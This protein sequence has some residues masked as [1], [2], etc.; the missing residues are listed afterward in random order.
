M[1]KPSLA[2]LLRDDPAWIDPEP[3]PTTFRLDTLDKDE[4]IA[5]LLYRRGIRDAESAHD[6][7]DAK[8][9]PPPPDS[10]VPHMPAAIDRVSRAIE[11]GEQVG[12]FGDYDVDGVTATALL[13]HALRIAIGPG[14]VLP[15]L[16]ERADGYGLSRGG[17]DRIVASGARLM[18]CVDCGSTDHENVAY[19]IANGLDVVILDH[20][21]MTDRGPDE[22]IVV[23]PQLDTDPTYQ[24]LTGVGLAYL[25]VLGL[26]ARNHRIVEDGDETQ[27]LDLVAL[28]TVA[29]VQPLLGLNRVF[30]RE[31]LQAI[32]QTPRPGIQAL[33]S[34]ARLSQRGIEASH[35][36]FQLAPRINAAGRLASATAALS[37]MLTDNGREALQLASQLN[38]HNLNRRGKQDRAIAEATKT[39]LAMP[40]WKTRGFVTVSHPDWETGLVGVVAGRLCETLRRPII[41]FRE[42]GD[43]LYG[44]ARSVT[45]FDIAAG[46]RGASSLLSNHG[47]HAQAAG[48]SLPVENLEAFTEAML[49]AVATCGTTIPAP[50]TI[51]IDADLDEA[52]ISQDTVKSIASLQPFGHGNH[53]PVF[54]IRNAQLNQYTTMSDGKHLKL[55]VRIGAKQFE[56]I[57]W[58]GGWRSPQ[59]VMARHLDLAGR[60]DINEFNGNTR[61]QMIL[62]DF[63]PS[64]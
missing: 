21:Q 32:R 35:I 50:K 27:Y 46:L 59:L 2:E 30:V 47:G 16:P 52:H 45:G 56:A 42:E 4:L 6:F 12:I 39:I 43:M 18:I 61:L 23:S 3:I 51:R 19:A 5:L 63:R 8:R 58:Q 64:E 40:D 41:V 62:E 49:E 11:K 15:V 1:T 28:G 13:T 53:Q 22:A 20:H 9:R 54:R 44:S 38:Q 14:Q 10:I 31:G 48:L 60:L 25:L 34:E 57:Q 29:D 36:A 17:I 7:L 55:S 33:I 24:S 26:A 37:L